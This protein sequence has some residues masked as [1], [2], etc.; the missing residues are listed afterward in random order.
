M[1]IWIALFCIFLS[2]LGFT[3]LFFW[4]EKV[5]SD[6]R[7]LVLYISQ[8]LTALA[9]LLIVLHI[10]FFSLAYLAIPTR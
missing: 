9:G 6:R 7:D 10:K 2:L 5:D 8:F 1:L 4:S 3:W